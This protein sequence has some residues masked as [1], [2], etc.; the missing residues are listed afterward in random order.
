M[1]AIFVAN[2]VPTFNDNVILIAKTNKAC[3]GLLINYSTSHNENFQK[4]KR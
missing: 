1:Y 3:K 4:E 2:L